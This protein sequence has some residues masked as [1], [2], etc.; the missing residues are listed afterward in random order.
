MWSLADATLQDML[1]SDAKRREAQSM[2]I[3]TQEAI[4]PHELNLSV[5]R[6]LPATRADMERV[7]P[8]ISR[9]QLAALPVVLRQ[10]N[11]PL[12]E[13]QKIFGSHVTRRKINSF[14]ALLQGMLEDTAKY[15]CWENDIQ[16]LLLDLD[17]IDV[18]F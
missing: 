8:S 5:W 3:F 11:T 10:G 4:V 1:I 15:Q 13:Y 7:D 6:F 18:S 17:K 16:A 12:S 2:L 9:A 14:R